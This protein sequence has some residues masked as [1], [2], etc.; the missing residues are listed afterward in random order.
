MVQAAPE[1]R[2]LT[3]IDALLPGRPAR[4]GVLSPRPAPVRF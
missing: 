2:G 3:R 4:L 1:G